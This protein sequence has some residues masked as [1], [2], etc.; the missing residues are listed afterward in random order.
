[1]T[2]LKAD[3]AIIRAMTHLKSPFLIAL[4]GLLLIAGCAKLATVERTSL[5][6]RSYGALET[7]LQQRPA[8]LDL[9][10]MLGPYFV[11]RDPNVL[12][13]LS[14]GESVSADLYLASHKDKAPLVIFMHGH[15]NSK[16]S[17]AQQAAHVASWGVH[18]LT[19]DLP[20]AGPWL[21]NGKTLARV[22]DFIAS[23]PAIFNNRVDVGRI[24]LVG[25]SFGGVAVTVALAEGARSSGGVLLDPASDEYGLPHYLRKISQPLLLVGA[26]RNVS[27]TLNRD[28]FY[29]YPS[30]G[31]AEVSVKGAAHEDA[32]DPPPSWFRNEE[33]HI[34][35]V[36]AITAAVLSLAMTRRFDYAW[37]S[38][39]GSFA[40]GRLI[41]AKKR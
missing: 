36:S 41:D 29:Q 15:G 18:C 2:I 13:R 8:E 9:F 11:T 26:D 7:L 28:Y 27:S 39:E 4:V 19:L 31:V 6:P 38:F 17:H 1:V 25:H 20:N 30:R 24:V 34:T 16:A 22:A 32:Q 5:K 10:R 23:Q 12:L 35:F 14:P 21:F 37:A 40:K 3:A 33:H